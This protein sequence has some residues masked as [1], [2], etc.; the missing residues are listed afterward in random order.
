M[1]RVWVRC[2][3]SASNSKNKEETGKD[4]LGKIWSFYYWNT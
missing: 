3:E 2:E 4:C 1:R